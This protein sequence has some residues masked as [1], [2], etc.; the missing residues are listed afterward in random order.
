MNPKKGDEESLVC[1]APHCRTF[2]RPGDGI[3]IVE[4]GNP[5]RLCFPCYRKSLEAKAVEARKA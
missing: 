1:H 3:Q 4:A 2:V 5:I